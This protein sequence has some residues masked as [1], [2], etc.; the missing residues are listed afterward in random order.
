VKLVIDTVKEV[1][2]AGIVKAETVGAVVSGGR[3][4]VTEALLLA[5]TLPAASFA[6]A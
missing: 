6:H 5:D 4:I 1:A 3:V 2:V